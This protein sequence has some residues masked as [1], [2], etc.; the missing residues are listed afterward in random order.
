[1]SSRQFQ[2]GYSKSGFATQAH[3]RSFAAEHRQY[4]PLEKKQLVADALLSGLEP[5]KQMPCPDIFEGFGIT[6]P[7]I[8]L[9]SQVV[10]DTFNAC[11]YRRRYLVETDRLYNAKSVK[12]KRKQFNAGKIHYRAKMLLHN[13][14]NFINFVAVSGSCCN[15]H[16]KSG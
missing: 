16:G 6:Q 2:D 11:R 15:F 4:P 8:L 9:D 14:D 1:M 10:S 7:K 3:H 12:N 13:R 5:M